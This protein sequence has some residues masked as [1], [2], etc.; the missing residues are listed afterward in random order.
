MQ[1]SALPAGGVVGAL[2]ATVIYLLVL[3]MDAQPLNSAPTRTRENNPNNLVVSLVFFMVFELRLNLKLR[4][5]V[6]CINVNA[7]TQQL[8]SSF[9]WPCLIPVLQLSGA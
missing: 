6:S 2:D 9:C 3:D 1:T 5:P 7:K 4:L 8:K